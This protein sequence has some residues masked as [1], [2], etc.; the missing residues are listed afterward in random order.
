MTN[1]T[2]IP[3]GYRITVTSW[4]NDADHYKTVV[5]EGLDEERTKLWAALCKLFQEDDDVRNLYEP[6]S[7]ERQVAYEIIAGV[8]R[9]HE[10]YM[11]YIGKESDDREI[12][13]NLLDGCL[14][15][16]GLTCQGEFWTRVCES[17]TVEFVENEIK[18]PDVTAAFM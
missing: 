14:F 13:E 10:K 1:F 5:K 9:K 12:A 11:E 8:A 15:E 16:M 6:D 2:I 18:I 17:F 7:D 3:A 4:E